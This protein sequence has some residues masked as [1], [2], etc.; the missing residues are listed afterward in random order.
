MNKIGDFIAD[1]RVERGLSRIELAQQL[2][3]SYKLIELIE[4]GRIDTD[5]LP[6]EKISLF[7]GVSKEEIKCGKKI[8]REDGSREVLSG[9]YEK[10]QVIL[11]KAKE[12]LTASAVVTVIILCA[13]TA[14]S[15]I[16]KS[17]TGF[18]IS[19]IMAAFFMAL[20]I[21]EAKKTAG[22]AENDIIGSEK[23][24]LYYRSIIKTAEKIICV[25]I[26]EI[27]FSAAFSF[28]EGLFIKIIISVLTVF[29][30]SALIIY[31]SDSHLWQA[32]KKYKSKSRKTAEKYKR[33]SRI[34]QEL[35]ELER[36][37]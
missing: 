30:F 3:I 28:F 20:F 2:G 22:Y 31:L 36:C 37:L 9:E 23:N 24:F 10:Y 7:F 17:V 21:K 13:A 16:M 1:L 4:D 14:I 27:T 5:D 11:Q 26:A 18:L 35:R 33:K 8:Y 32:E 34:D 12:K 25:G 15:V 29:A 6:I 19:N